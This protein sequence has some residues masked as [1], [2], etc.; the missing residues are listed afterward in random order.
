M[1]EEDK[2]KEDAK[3]GIDIA[4]RFLSGK[5]IDASEIKKATASINKWLK[6]EAKV[7]EVK[8]RKLAELKA[9]KREGL[10]TDRE[11]KSEVSKLM[12]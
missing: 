9:Q 5:K 2:I 11:F 10:I 8:K 6:Y 7:A 12:T 4:K 3:R 1:K